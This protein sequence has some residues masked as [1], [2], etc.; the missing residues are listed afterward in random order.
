MLK[1]AVASIALLIIIGTQFTVSASSAENILPPTGRCVIEFGSECA[2]MPS[3]RAWWVLNGN[4]VQFRSNH[5]RSQHR[6][7]GNIGS[8]VVFSPWTAANRE[9]F[10][11]WV[12][13]PANA[14]VG[15]RLET[16]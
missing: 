8:N 16:R 11:A 10:S 4:N 12:S 3:G 13:R 9:S 15:V 6:A 1:L 2:V 7:R 14:Q 5:N